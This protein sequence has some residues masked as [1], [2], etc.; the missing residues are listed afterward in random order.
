MLAAL[1]MFYAILMCV[2]A[3]SHDTL[4]PNVEAT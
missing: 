1:V 4:V 3:A 2:S